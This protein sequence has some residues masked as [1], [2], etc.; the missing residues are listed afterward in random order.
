VINCTNQL[1]QRLNPPLNS[2]FSESPP[3]QRMDRLEAH[4]LFFARLVTSNAG[5]S[6]AKDRLIEAFSSVRREQFV[7]LVLGKYLP[8]AASSKHPPLIPRFFTRTYS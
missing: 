5:A 7:A 3:E 2:R 8:A 4:R 6:E 1:Q